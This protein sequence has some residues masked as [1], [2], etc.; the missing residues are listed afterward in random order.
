MLTNKDSKRREWNLA[1]DRSVH[2]R[3][4]TPPCLVLLIGSVSNP[5]DRNLEM[6]S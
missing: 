2:D 1:S 3:P 4:P 6:M 5:I